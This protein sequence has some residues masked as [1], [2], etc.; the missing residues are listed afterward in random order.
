[1]SGAAMT[2]PTKVVAPPNESASAH[3]S[4]LL[5]FAD[6]L[7]DLERSRIATENRVRS[8]RQIKGMDGT[9]EE[10]RLLALVDGIAALEHGAE[11][12]LK[13]ALRAHPIG[14]WIKAQVGLGEKQA[15]RLLAAIGD[16]YLRE[17]GTTRTVSQLWAYCGLHVL[18][19]GQARTDTHLVRA[20]VEPSS[21]PG[22]SAPVS[23]A[24]RAGVA[25][26]RARGQRANWNTTA[27]M[28]AYL[29]AESCIKQARSPFRAV[30][31]AGRAKYT[32]ALHAVE[33]VRCGPRGNPAPVGSPLSAGHQHARAMR[34]VS[35]EILKAL[36][37]ESRRLAKGHPEPSP[38]TRADDS[39][40]ERGAA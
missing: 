34:L 24:F 20:G 36:W 16:P 26:K 23:H 33:C 39:E 13:R 29:C 17:D 14:P 4:L 19:P 31:D 6:A 38:R 25:P 8:L 1:M 30:Y 15:G 12:E 32:D 27:K 11:L 22:Q 7:D 28:R 35:K 3:D 5:I 37:I 9:P 40:P 2:E 10:I 18:H 21:D